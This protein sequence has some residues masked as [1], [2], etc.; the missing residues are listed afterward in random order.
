MVT[1]PEF[2]LTRRCFFARAA[3]AA[4][5]PSVAV[6][7]LAA[8]PVGREN[9]ASDSPDLPAAT[10]LNSGEAPAYLLVFHT[11]QEVM[12]GLLE[13]AKK[14]DLV[15]G[16]VTG[17]GAL[18]SAVIG[19]FDPATNAYLRNQQNEQ[20]ELVSLV[21]NLALNNNEPF[22]H[23]HVG[24]GLRDGSARGGHL[25]EAIVRPT[26]E[27]IMTTSSR[28]VRREIDRVTGLPLLDASGKG[29]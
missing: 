19:Y 15:A 8:A 9:S 12:K 25:F 3:V 11:G 20:A 18:S 16:Y 17:I 5:V 2:S 26:V 4:A 10:L 7:C 29:A 28:P 22:F 14:H 27:L 13:F 1:S 6:A 23:I 24:L 21:G